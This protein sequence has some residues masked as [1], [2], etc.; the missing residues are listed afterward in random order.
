MV[1]VCHF[2]TR[3][4]D[5]TFTQ[6]MKDFFKHTLAT[7]LGI[8]LFIGIS[9]AFFIFSL[10]GTLLSSSSKVEVKDNSVLVLNLKGN[11]TEKG[12]G[13]PFGAI[14]GSESS[15][16]GL[17]DILA[18]IDKAKENDDIKG[19]YIE[20]GSLATDYASLQEIRTKLLEFKKSKKWIVS[21]ADTYAQGTYY[22]ASVADKM[23]LNPSGHVD[24]HGIGSQP[25][26][27]KD[28]LAKV[29]VRM[30]IV[31]VGTY[32]SATETYSEDHMS[33]ANREQVSKY[34]GGIWTVVVNDVAKSRNLSVETLNKYADEMLMF[35]EAT[36]L[37]QKKV[38]DEL[39]YADQVKAAIKKRLGIDA[40]EDINQLTVSDMK[41]IDGT[42]IHGTSGEKI[43]VYYC[44]GNIVQSATTGAIMGSTEMIVGSDFCKAMEKFKKDDDI[45]AVVIRINTGGGDAYA[46]EQ[47]WHYLSELKKVKPVVIS[48]GGVTASGG[49]YT[50]CNA[51][52]IFAE[53]TTIT[54]SI[55]IFG[56]FPDFSNLMTQKLGI[57]YD[58]VKTNKNSTFSPVGMARPMNAEELSYMQTYIN[59]GY[60]LFRKRVA[61]GRK[62]K[63]ED[64]EKIAQG[65]VWLATDALKLKLVDKLGTLDDAIA[66]AAELAKV[67]VYYAA[68]YPAEA[69][70]MEQLMKKAEGGTG[71]ALDEQLRLVLGA[72]YEPF[73][74]VRTIKEQSPIQARIPYVLNIK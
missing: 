67:K 6:K 58:E 35:Q 28:L 59:N 40:D 9:I 7:V 74:M 17:N 19:I 51:S 70:F 34:I 38:I 65:R 57:H 43:A 16:T 31:K 47:M 69:G 2:L 45:K 60:S 73:F 62:M 52:Y 49:Y 64:V 42:G 1:G 56:M 30:E 55:G 44:E 33:D 66:K 61:D 25:E 15:A 24:W 50:S 68:E 71:T 13:D 36:A 21:Y 20:A 32:K 27:Y 11:L 12:S 63:V 37:K 22:L 4:H 10:V 23:Y 18:A 29:G 8:F 41:E 72:Y 39:L 3:H 14:L 53:P 54:G 48:M 46:S 26:Y 5:F